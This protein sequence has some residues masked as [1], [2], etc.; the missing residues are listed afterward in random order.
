V[1][2][3]ESLAEAISALAGEVGLF[4]TG[5]A[6]GG[7][8]GEVGGPAPL[9]PQEALDLLDRAEERLRSGDWAGFGA[10]LEELRTLLRNMAGGGGGPDE[11]P[12]SI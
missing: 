1:A 3:E 4:S 9:W 6:L 5:R 10:A 11:G 12:P 7:S 8:A 2:M